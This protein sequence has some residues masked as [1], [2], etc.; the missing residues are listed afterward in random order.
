MER[1]KI[2]IMNDDAAISSHLSQTLYS[3]G[4][5]NQIELSHKR[6]VAWLSDGNTPVLT[7]LN[8]EPAPAAGLN[9]LAGIRDASP[10]GRVIV[11]GS[12][13]QLRFIVD[14]LRF[15]ASDYIVTP[16]DKEQVHL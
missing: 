1:R 4:Y 10:T 16:F 15:G 2:L 3:L 8:I 9:V 7:I 5:I 11:I 13:S 6:G 12:G 14:A